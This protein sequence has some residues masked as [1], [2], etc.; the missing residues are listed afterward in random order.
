MT[1]PRT[2]PHSCRNVP[3][4]PV[5]EFPKSPCAPLINQEGRCLILAFR[6][7]G[8]AVITSSWIRALKR[9]IP[10]LK[11]H[12]LGRPELREVFTAR[13][14]IETYH[15]INLP[16]F[17]HHR[18][19]LNSI[20]AA[21]G[22]MRRLRQYRYDFC[23]NLVG[24]TRENLIGRLIGSRWNIA[25]IW[26]PG[27]LFKEKITDT[28]AGLLAN[29][30]IAIP[31]RIKNYYEALDF[32]GQRLGLQPIQWS[33]PKS[34][35]GQTSGSASTARIALHPGASHPSRRWPVARWKELMRQLHG[36]GC[37]M[38]LLGSPVEEK[39]LRET[40]QHEI[41][42]LHLEVITTGMPEFFAALRGADLLI[43]MDSLSAHAAY[44]MGTRSVVM[45]GSSDPKIMTPPGSVPLSA[46]HLCPL[47]PCN[48]AYLCR[49]QESPYVCCRG[50]EVPEVLKAVDVLL[51][52]RPAMGPPE[53]S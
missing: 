7:L 22:S 24:D 6:H 5:M 39:H 3:D 34:R 18:R 42:Q 41:E 11:I 28:G 53:F 32:F 4:S 49:E 26:S 33:D 36:R 19:N 52:R 10:L 14:T 9:D 51:T 35:S 40:Y 8:D 23:I 12:V 31:T 21:F 2:E 27:H 15:T 1:S 17:G 16:V 44:S 38:E 50:I 13:C 46:G 29:C 43:G 25:P 20:L 30:G 45:N 48:Y 47:F 37:R